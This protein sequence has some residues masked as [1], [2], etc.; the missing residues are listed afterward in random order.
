VVVEIRPVIRY[1]RCEAGY[2]GASGSI[3]IELKRE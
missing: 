2:S 3:P 1:G